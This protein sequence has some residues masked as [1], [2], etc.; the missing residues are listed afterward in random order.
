MRTQTLSKTLRLAVVGTVLW[1]GGAQ[2]ASAS[3]IVQSTGITPDSTFGNDYL[4]TF[5]ITATATD[6]FFPDKSC[7]YFTIEGLPGSV[8]TV[9]APQYWQASSSAAGVT[10]KW[11]SGAAPEVPGSAT[12]YLNRGDFRIFL[13]DGTPTDLTYV[14]Q[15]YTTYPY[16]GG[17]LQSGRGTISFGGSTTSVPEP[18]TL[19]LLGLGLA[20][21][22]WLRRPRRIGGQRHEAAFAS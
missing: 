21:A 11:G 8:V 16:V 7:C 12:S 18:A 6:G 19:S 20:V 2:F 3:I 9:E 13:T 1:V 10:F 14:W 4:W 17:Q 5:S 15:D 22:A